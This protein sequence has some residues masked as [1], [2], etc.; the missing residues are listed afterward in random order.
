VTDQD[1]ALKQTATQALIASGFPFQTSIARLVRGVRDCESVKE[2]FP[3]QEGFFDLLAI[4][5]NFIVVVE[6]K[7]TQKEILTFLQPVGTQD[8]IIVSRCAHLFRTREQTSIRSSFSCADWF[9]TPKSYESAFCVVSTSES[10]KDQRLL[11]RDAQLLVRGI[12]GIG[13]RLMHDRT[14]PFGARVFVPIIVTNAKLFSALYD[15]E[16]VSL[17]T[18]QIPTMPAPNLSPIEWVR[19]RKAFTAA[20]DP[21]LGDRTVFVVAA[22]SLQKFLT[23]LDWVDVDYRERRC[24]E[25]EIHSVCLNQS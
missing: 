2:E 23:A 14:G 8:P 24:N 25:V 6:C 18:G 16:D 1:S 12:D 17:D 4:L 21:G 3:W 13:I 11:E 5:R 10:G 19:F 22:N 20:N 15:P 7:K 9:L